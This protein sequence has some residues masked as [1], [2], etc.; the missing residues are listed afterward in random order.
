MEC[1]L[2]DFGISEKK[3]FKTIYSKGEMVGKATIQVG[4]AADRKERPLA[5]RFESNDAAVYE[6]WSQAISSSFDLLKDA[7]TRS[8]DLRFTIVMPVLV[9]PENTLWV[10]DYAEDGTRLTEPAVTDECTFFLGKSYDIKM[11][12]AS[13]LNYTL[14]HLHIVTMKGL[15]KLLRFDEDLVEDLFFAR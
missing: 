15:N 9:V 14:S 13:I 8:N 4:K 3:G 6:K 5:E 2:L 12:D 10:V 1:R 11:P 7:A